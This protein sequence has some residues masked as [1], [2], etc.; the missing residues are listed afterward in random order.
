M[1]VPL[2]QYPTPTVCI[3]L[4]RPDCE[5][6][7]ASCPSQASLASCGRAKKYGTVRGF[8][9][10]DP[11]GNWL[12][13][14]KLGDTEQED[15]EKTEGLAKIIHVAARLGDAHGDELLAL[16]TLESGLTRYADARA[17]D[18]AKAH[19]YRAELSLRTK[20]YEMARSSLAAAKSLKLTEAERA[21]LAEEF[22]H[23]TELIDQEST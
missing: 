16:K 6:G 13:I 4:S 10:V 7:M 19:L 21:A 22:A 3:M 15:S 12:R 5:D 8:S 11:G 1:G 18:L 14:Y 2:W 23:I 20:N 9:V 17:A